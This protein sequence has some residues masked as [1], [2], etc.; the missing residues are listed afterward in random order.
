MTNLLYTNISVC[1][2]YIYIRILYVCNFHWYKFV[3]RYHTN[4]FTLGREKIFVVGV[5]QGRDRKGVGVDKSESLKLSYKSQNF[6]II[7][8]IYETGITLLHQPPFSYN[9]SNPLAKHTCCSRHWLYFI[10]CD[11]P[12]CKERDSLAQPH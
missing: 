7:S 4:N 3:T 11:Y 5:D 8:V 10:S 12:S 9:L 6:T 2:I 1:F